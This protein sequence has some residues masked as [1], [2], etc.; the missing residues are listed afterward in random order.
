MRQYLKGL[1]TMR[2]RQGISV[3]LILLGVIFIWRTYQ[4]WT[5]PILAPYLVPQFFWPP[6]I[7]F[8]IPLILVGSYFVCFPYGLWQGRVRPFF[9]YTIVLIGMGCV[10]ALL[11]DNPTRM[12]NPDGVTYVLEAP[13][14]K[15]FVI[16]DPYFDQLSGG[17]MRI[18]TLALGVPMWAVF[19]LARLRARSS[20]GE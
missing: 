13:N 17:F 7:A 1:S 15:P 2:L 6:I 16:K 12:F 9:I 11:Q 20:S 19:L 5:L 10:L 3:L 8:G 4:R 18:A 14:G